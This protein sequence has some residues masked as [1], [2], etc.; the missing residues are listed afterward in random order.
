MTHRAQPLAAISP[1]TT[2]E[3]VA[4]YSVLLNTA[5]ATW[6]YVFQQTE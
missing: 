1:E 2:I 6:V 3:L 4:L 5:A